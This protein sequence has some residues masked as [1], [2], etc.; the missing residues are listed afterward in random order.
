MPIRA[1]IRTVYTVRLLI[2]QAR[3]YRTSMSC[4]EKTGFSHFF[5]GALKLASEAFPWQPESLFAYTLDNHN[6]VLGI[7]ESALAA[8]ATAAAVEP[9]KDPAGIEILFKLSVSYVRATVCRATETLIWSR[10]DTTEE[11]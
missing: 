4:S 7:R 3:Y 6:S 8:G 5:T 9:Y 2:P 10:L 1:H 11:V